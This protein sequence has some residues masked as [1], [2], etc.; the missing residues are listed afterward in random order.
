MLF[1]KWLVAFFSSLQFTRNFFFFSKFQCGMGRCGTTCVG[2]PISQEMVRLVQINWSE[3]N[4]NKKCQSFIWPLESS[5]SYFSF[6]HSSSV[7][8]IFSVSRVSYLEWVIFAF[9]GISATYGNDMTNMHPNFVFFSSCVCSFVSMWNCAGFVSNKTHDWFE[10][11][12]FWQTCFNWWWNLIRF[13]MVRRYR[14]WLVC[15]FIS[16]GAI[17]DVTNSRWHSFV[18]THS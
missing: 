7:L 5:F 10:S 8:M 9:D 4:Q 3:I 2:M 15:T 11:G 17:K 16:F 18:V 14:S 13:R 12:L 6:P 1:I